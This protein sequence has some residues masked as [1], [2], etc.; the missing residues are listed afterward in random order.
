MSKKVISLVLCFLALA[1]GTVSAQTLTVSGAVTDSSTGEGIP[2]ASVM[3]KGTMNGNS[4]DA[5]GAYTLNVSNP[6][7][8]VLVFS[9]V[10]YASAE[11][12]VS[13][14]S[15]IDV[16]LEP[17]NRL[18]ETIVIAYGTATRSSFTGSATA[19]KSET[20]EK[21]LTNSVTNA[22][23]GTTAGVQ[24]LASSGDPT[25]GSPTI[26]I[27]GIGSMSA[28][29]SPLIVVDGVPYSGTISDINPQD[30]AE[31]TVLKDASASAIYGARGANGVILITTKRGEA[32]DAVVKLDVRMGVNSRLIPQ[33][34]VIDDPGEYYEQ[35]YKRMF[36][37]YLYSGNY[38]TAQAYAL[39][40]RNILDANNGG[41]GYLVYT[42]PEGQKLIGTNFKLNPNATLGYSDGEYYYT[43]DDWYKEAF[44][45]SFRQEYNL[46]VSGAGDKFNYYASAG[47]LDDSG[48]IKHSDY[49]RY[50]GRINA[51]YQAKEWMRFITS[52]TFSHSDSAN[53]ASTSSWG[54]SG[55][56]FYIVNNMGPIY[57]LYVRNADGT[58][59]K[60]SGRT[61]YDANQTNFSRPSVVGN[62]VRDNE[63]DRRKNLADVLT[64]KIGTVITPIEGLSITA[65][66]GLMDDNTRYNAL[67]SVFGSG[68]ATD[69]SAYTS[70][71]R[72]WTVNQQYLAEYKRNFGLHG[73]DVL[74]GFEQ[75]DLKY[76]SLSGSNDHLFD[77]NNGELNNADGKANMYA[78][79]YTNTYRTKGFLGRAQYDYDEKY[80]VNGSI[81]RDAS[82]RFAPGHQWG[83]FWSL[84]GGVA[85]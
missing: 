37:S 3:V 25:G 2:F 75:Y 14:R 73:I 60:E 68:N 30:V 54:S 65:N 31:M 23:S 19:V 9:A 41:L 57:P 71:S 27:R 72:T 42:V 16:A 67:Y 40:D 50:T 18:D 49:K 15:K 21:K 51:E 11:I 79:S 26:R 43:P 20:I 61:V 69:G 8:A 53:S 70:H 36:N 39:A 46:S 64:A 74:G 66:V 62:A 32:G 78:N 47:F 22:L 83:T 63:Y 58:I 59:K 55:N 34:D 6:S 12:S 56:L 76:Q 44:R 85:D 4:A 82:S 29:N 13:G 38:T 77:P 35:V 52:A 28:S 80:Y 17:D 7:S 33:Y 5:D 10:G 84:G 48:I 81:R 45:N 24:V 1:V